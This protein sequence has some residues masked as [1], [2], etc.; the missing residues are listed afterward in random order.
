MGWIYLRENRERVREALQRGRV[1]EV[2]TLRATAFDDLAAMMYTF[3][4]WKQLEAIEVTLDKDEDDVPNELLLRLSLIHIS[5]PTRP[6]RQS[7]MPS[8]A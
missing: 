4:Y 5:E 6:R 7:R 3:G 8:S 2:V 1:D